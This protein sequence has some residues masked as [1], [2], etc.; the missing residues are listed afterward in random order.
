MSVDLGLLTSCAACD[1]VPY[2]HCH[3][4]PPVVSFQQLQRSELSWVSHRS[5]VVI[6]S[7]DFPLK[8]LVGRNVAPVPKEY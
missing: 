7:H 5:K 1:V 6:P 8:V 4:G 2:E 3:T